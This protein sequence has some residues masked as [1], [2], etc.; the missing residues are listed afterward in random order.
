VGTTFQQGRPGGLFGKHFTA[1][2][3]IL[4]LVVLVISPAATEPRGAGIITSR[5]GA[6]D[7]CRFVPRVSFAAE[8]LSIGL[9]SSTNLTWSVQTRPGCVHSLSMI[10]L[11]RPQINLSPGA[12]QDWAVWTSSV[13]VASQPQG[14]VQVQP[15]FNTLYLLIVA[16]G[17]NS[18][19]YSAPVQVAVTLPLA[20]RTCFDVANPLS[21]ASEERAKANSRVTAPTGGRAAVELRIVSRMARGN[22]TRASW[23]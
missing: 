16:W 17:P 12:P 15:A 1:S 2:F 13:G 5:G 9:G 10:V 6:L 3:G 4:A 23:Q 18:A 19:I 11:A 14:S 20:N 21:G 8:S 7:G 22:H